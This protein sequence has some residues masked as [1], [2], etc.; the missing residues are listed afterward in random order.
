[1]K[2]VIGIVVLGVVVGSVYLLNNLTRTEDG[3]SRLHVARELEIEV[4]ITQPE[5]RVIFQ[6]VQA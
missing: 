6:T 2:T 5:Q 4:E 3:K 1:M